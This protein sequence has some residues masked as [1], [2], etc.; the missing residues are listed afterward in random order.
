MG[1]RYFCWRKCWVG[2]VLFRWS[3]LFSTRCLL[4]SNS[5]LNMGCVVVGFVCLR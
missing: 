4:F 1:K 3:V 5:V 2:F